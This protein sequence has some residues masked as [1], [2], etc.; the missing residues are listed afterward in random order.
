MTAKIPLILLKKWEPPLHEILLNLI[1]LLIFLSDNFLWV[2]LLPPVQGV[3]AQFLVVLCNLSQIL[4]L[5]VFEC[6]QAFIF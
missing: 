4:R 5:P 6:A 3:A 2:S 1:V